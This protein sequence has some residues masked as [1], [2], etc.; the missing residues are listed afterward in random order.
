V[1]EMLVLEDVEGNRPVWS[2]AT[3]RRLSKVSGGRCSYAV[4]MC[5]KF[6]VNTLP[7]LDHRVTP[8]ES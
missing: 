3:S 1:F 6:F 4:A 2:I 8:V 7:R 5:G